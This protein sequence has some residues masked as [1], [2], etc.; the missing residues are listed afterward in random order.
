MSFF[1]N[2]LTGEVLEVGAGIGINLLDLSRSAQRWTA[3]EPD[4]NLFTQLQQTIQLHKLKNIDAIHGTLDQ[5]A[6]DRKFDNILYVD[7]LEHIQE[8]RTEIE[9]AA[10]KLKSG[11]HLVILAPAHQQL[12]SEFDQ[13]IGHYRRYDRQSLGALAPPSLQMIR[14]RYLDSMGAL[15]SFSNRFFLHQ[16]YPSLRQILFWDRVIIPISKILDGV[17]GY[18]FGKSILA[19]WTRL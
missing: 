1:S 10:S 4:P 19:I 11:G 16:A 8:D 12:F 6:E 3:L 17:L 13:S 5:I 14:M 9:K 18:R 7:V 2:E 15:L